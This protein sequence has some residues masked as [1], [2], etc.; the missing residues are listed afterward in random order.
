[1]DSVKWM[2][3]ADMEPDDVMVSDNLLEFVKDEDIVTGLD[4]HDDIL[5]QGILQFLM[6]F[7]NGFSIFSDFSHFFN[8][9]IE[10]AI[11]LIDF[12]L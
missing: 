10:L 3:S 12:F 7:R 2:H 4:T 11:Y 9:L 8:N 1:M 5:P 6:Q